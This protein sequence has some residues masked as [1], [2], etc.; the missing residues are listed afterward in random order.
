MSSD[1]LKRKE[2]EAELF[3]SPSPKKKQAPLDKLDL[4]ST[5]VLDKSGEVSWRTKG[6]ESTELKKGF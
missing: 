2:S 5:K 1:H 3:P 6:I 4:P